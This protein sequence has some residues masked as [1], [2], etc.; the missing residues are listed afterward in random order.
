MHAS[1]DSS[2]AMEVALTI[3]NIDFQAAPRNAPSCIECRRKARLALSGDALPDITQLGD[4]P[5][6]ICECGAFSKCLPGTI[7][8][9]ARPANETTRQLRKAAMDARDAWCA[10]VAS[11]N[12]WSRHRA[13]TESGR[14]A[15]KNRI[16]CDTGWVSKNSLIHSE[17]VFREA[18]G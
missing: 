13:H 4:R 11:K 9:S 7:I 17:K 1:P 5:I 12:G 8:P 16:A 15:Y 10:W 18:I 3:Q 2:S 14:F 6:W